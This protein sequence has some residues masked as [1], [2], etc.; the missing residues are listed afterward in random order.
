MGKPGSERAW[1]AAR[2]ASSASSRTGPPRRRDSASTRRTCS[3]DVHRDSNTRSNGNVA[4]PLRARVRKKACARNSSLA[5]ARSIVSSRASRLCS[6]TALW[7]KCFGPILK[8]WAKRSS[9]VVSPS[10]CKNIAIAAYERAVIF[11][12]PD[13]AAHDA[14]ARCSSLSACAELAEAR[15]IAHSC[16]SDATPLCS[17]CAKNDAASDMQPCARSERSRCVRRLSSSVGV[18]GGNS[19]GSPLSACANCCASHVAAA[20]L[21]PSS[22]Q[23]KHKYHKRRAAPKTT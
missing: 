23:R 16:D 10:R 15:S 18:A 20:V 1:R 8:L 22:L 9:A 19:R 12:D 17:S 2:A 14:A 6:T 3:S 7:P 4:A 21:S 11:R 5:P 13:W